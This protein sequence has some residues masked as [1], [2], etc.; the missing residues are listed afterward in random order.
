MLLLDLTGLASDSVEVQFEPLIEAVGIELEAQNKA[1]ASWDP[2]PPP[3]LN[4]EAEEADISNE[5]VGDPAANA[6]LFGR[7]MGQISA[8]IERAWMRPR[9][10]VA[11]GRFTCRARIAQDRSGKVLSVELQDCDEDAKWRKSLTSAIR[12]ASP[13]SAP[14][15][16]RLFADT[17]TLA[18]SGEQYVPNRTSEHLYEPA[19]RRV[20]AVGQ[21]AKSLP[22][23]EGSGD[24]ELTIVGDEV[25][26]I[27]KATTTAPEKSP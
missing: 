12:R 4:I 3:V 16:K 24:F 10:A 23:L 8:R 19:P 9:S 11:G 14:P 26:W 18:F 2:N 13:L 22:K 21:P 25:R 27:R 5:A 6:A 15:E 7:Y 1:L 20:A 17:L